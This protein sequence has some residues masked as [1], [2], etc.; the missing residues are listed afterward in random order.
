MRDFHDAKFDLP[1]GWRRWSL[2]VHK[3][4]NDKCSI[5]NDQRMPS[6]P[7]SRRLPIVRDFGFDSPSLLWVLVVRSSKLFLVNGTKSPTSRYRHRCRPA[8]T[9]P[10]KFPFVHQLQ[11]ADIGTWVL[12]FL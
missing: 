11:V 2:G 4:V 5:S 12:G 7:N 9:C 6:V 8:I 1:K 3:P 10:P